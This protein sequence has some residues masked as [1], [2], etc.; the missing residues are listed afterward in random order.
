MPCAMTVAIAAPRTPM[1]K[2]RINSRSSTMLSRLQN[3]RKISG[4]LESPSALKI[5]NGV[6]YAA[7]A[8]RP[9]MKIY[10]YV[11]A[12][13]IR[14]SGVFNNN[15]TGFVVTSAMTVM[16]KAINIQV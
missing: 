1:P 8:I 10:I 15:K 11:S 5:E 4:V 3:T 6:K 2:V 14:D 16:I 9:P 7:T 12:S 13:G